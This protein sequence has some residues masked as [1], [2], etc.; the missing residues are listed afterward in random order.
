MADW[1]TTHPEP[2][3]IGKI[4]FDMTDLDGTQ[5]NISA[6]A[7]AEIIDDVG[8]LIGTRKVDDMKTHLTAPEQTDLKNIMDAIRAK[9][10]AKLIP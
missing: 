9:A 5:G 8:N 10:V 3:S 2:A 6:S 7:T 1:E 4:T